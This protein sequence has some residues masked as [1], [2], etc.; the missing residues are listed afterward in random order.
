MDEASPL[1][2]L[3]SK[4]QTFASSSSSSTLEP[5]SPGEP[6]QVEDGGEVF[7]PQDKT[8]AEMSLDDPVSDDLFELA[9]TAEN[10]DQKK[11]LATTD[12]QRCQA[13]LA[14]KQSKAS[15]IAG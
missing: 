1:G 11:A 10:W 9:M 15:N 7:N 14:K 3:R 2:Q 12:S 13:W 8:V 6:S 4:T 5:G